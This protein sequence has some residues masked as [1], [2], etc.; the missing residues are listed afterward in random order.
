MVTEPYRWDAGLSTS[1]AVAPVPFN[2]DVT[3]PPGMPLTDRAAVLAPAAV[4]VKWTLTEQ[5]PPAASVA[6]HE[7]AST[8]KSAVSVP[9]TTTEIGPEALCPVLVTA[10]DWLPELAPTATEPYWYDRGAIESLAG[11]GVAADADADVI[12][13][14]T[15]ASVMRTVKTLSSRLAELGY[16]RMPPAPLSGHQALA[17]PAGEKIIR[18]SSHLLDPGSSIFNPMHAIGKQLCPKSLINCLRLRNSSY[19]RRSGHFPMCVSVPPRRDGRR[20]GGLA[21]ER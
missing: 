10:K 4:G 16:L 3:V 1:F 5:A 11:F 14:K 19:W 18:T 6:V 2:D 17:A 9:V 21:A 20:V 15:P 12:K 13:E 7:S 8:T